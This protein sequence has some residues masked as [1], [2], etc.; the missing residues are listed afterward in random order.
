MG[1]GKKPQ[2]IKMA[3]DLFNRRTQSV[4]LFCGQAS[5]KLKANMWYVPPAWK[6]HPSLI[7]SSQA[8]FVI[9]AVANC[10]YFVTQ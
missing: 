3:L 1:G 7:Q 5:Q 10:N 6:D 2:S 8:P 4:A 9:T